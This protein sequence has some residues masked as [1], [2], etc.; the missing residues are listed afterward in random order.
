MKSVIA[1]R[2]GFLEMILEPP[3]CPGRALSGAGEDR[4][5]LPVQPDG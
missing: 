4:M 2:L 1:V 3:R 5:R